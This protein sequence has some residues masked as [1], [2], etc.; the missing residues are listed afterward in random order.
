MAN[1]SFDATIKGLRERLDAAHS[2]LAAALATLPAELA[3]K[4]SEWSVADCLN[5]L[6]PREG[7]YSRYLETLLDQPQPAARAF[8]QERRWSHVKEWLAAEHQR[9]RQALARVTPERYSTP[10]AQPDG[11]TRPL[12]QYVNT[13]VSHFEEHTSQVLDQILPR[14]RA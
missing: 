5:H 4:G 3:Y 10:V 9:C 13:M 2:R 8:S 1:Q 11:S 6:S 12:S 7:G 14:V